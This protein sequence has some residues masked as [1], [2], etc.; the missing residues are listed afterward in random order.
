MQS[1]L[2]EDPDASSESDE[3]KEEMFDVIELWEI[4]LTN[5]ILNY[6]FVCLNYLFLWEESSMRDLPTPSRKSLFSGGGLKLACNRAPMATV[7]FIEVLP[8]V[9]V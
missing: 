6:S 5:S 3:G 1:L 2:D 7:V 4:Y 9:S 8:Q